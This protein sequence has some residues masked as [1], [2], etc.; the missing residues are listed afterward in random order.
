MAMPSCLMHLK[1][2]ISFWIQFK[3][4]YRHKVY[5]LLQLKEVFIFYCKFGTTP[6]SYCQFY[7]PKEPFE[8]P[9]MHIPSLYLG[10]YDCKECN[11]RI[12]YQ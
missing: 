11:K 4:F 10:K 2:Q 5:F 6:K 7:T 9:S 3:V 1:G 8:S 12:H